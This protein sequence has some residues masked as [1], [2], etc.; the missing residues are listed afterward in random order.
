MSTAAGDGIHVRVCCKDWERLRSTVRMPMESNGEQEDA[1]LGCVVDFPGLT[2]GQWLFLQPE[3]DR[4]AI[5]YDYIDHALE[6]P[7]WVR[8]L[9]SCR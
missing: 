8:Q 7:R 2:P 3:L 6:E 9:T 4:A 1:S 5:P